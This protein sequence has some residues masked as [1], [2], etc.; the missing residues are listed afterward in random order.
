[1]DEEEEEMRQYRLEIPKRYTNKC[2]SEHHLAGEQEGQDDVN[3]FHSDPGC[4]PR[5]VNVILSQ[6][7]RDSLELHVNGHKP[8][9]TQKSHGVAGHETA[10]F[11]E[12]C[13]Q[14]EDDL[15][16]LIGVDGLDDEEEDDDEL[17]G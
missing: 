17:I 9:T 16:H 3:D 5:E 13:L 14:I 10:S 12:A 4:I 2:Q 15:P 7:R 6:D 8:P 11:D 1:M